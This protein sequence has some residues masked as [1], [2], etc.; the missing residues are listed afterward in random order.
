MYL[1]RC[2]AVIVHQFNMISDMRGSAK[3]RSV[4]VP[5]LCSSCGK[6]QQTPCDLE[7][8]NPK[9]IPTTIK[10]PSCRGDME[11]DDILEVYFAFLNNK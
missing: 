9:S 5:Y 4:M 11:F 1:E 8:L 7:S 3:V 6:E 2:S 10:C